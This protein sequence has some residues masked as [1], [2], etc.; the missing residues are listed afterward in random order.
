MCTSVPCTLGYKIGRKGG[1]DATICATVVVVAQR[2][3]EAVCTLLTYYEKASRPAGRVSSIVHTSTSRNDRVHV[4]ATRIVQ[5]RPQLT[6][7]PGPPH[8]PIGL[9]LFNAHVVILF[10]DLLHLQI[11]CRL[12]TLGALKQVHEPLDMLR[13][14]VIR[15]LL[16]QCTHDLV[17]SVRA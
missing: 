7:V 8:D 13:N 5:F 1:R 2:S 4:I 10:L 11:L 17:N 12:W 3:V 14:C 6:A 15:L 16:V 9:Y